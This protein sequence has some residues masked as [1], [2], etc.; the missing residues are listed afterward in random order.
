MHRHA[1]LLLFCARTHVDAES[2]TE[3]EALCKDESDWATFLALAQHHRVVPLVYRTLAE[4]CPDRVPASILEELRAL[5]Q[6]N[7]RRSLLL[8]GQL[9]KLIGRFESSRIRA[10]PY[11]GPMIATSAYGDLS[12][13]QFGDLDVLVHQRDYD[14]ARECLESQGFRLVKEFNWESSYADPSD[15]VVVD[16]H[17]SLN[18]EL[19]EFGVDFERLWD[20]RAPIRIGGRDLR[21][22]SPE[23]MLSILCIQAARDGWNGK[24]RLLQRCDIAELVRSH[25]ELNW[26]WVMDEAR[27][28][29]TRRILLVGL[30]FCE[31]YLG[32]DLTK[33]VLR[34]IEADSRVSEIASQQAARCFQDH[35]DGPPRRID[36][37]RA[38]SEARERLRDK[39]RPY[40][41]QYVLEKLKPNS[42]DRAFLPLPE[43]LHFLYFVVRPFRLIADLAR[44]L[45]ARLAGLR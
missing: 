11:K 36:L 20:R 5:D 17:R 9:L 37:I 14:R 1:R 3:I 23:D 7:G 22:P 13:R 16:L 35:D 38:H 2:A 44:G 31:K 27:G 34:A 45:Y 12:L 10:I 32:A 43:A 42:S 25:P 4:R 39:F 29:G 21:S 24:Y 19:F 15:Q 41:Q 28:R 40:A 18:P 6:A 33:P 26:K 30:R 8:T